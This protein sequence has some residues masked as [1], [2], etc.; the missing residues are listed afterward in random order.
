M[1]EQVGG[2]FNEAAVVAGRERGNRVDRATC[3]HGLR[4]RGDRG[5]VLVAVYTPG[6]TAQ[7]S[8]LR[9]AKIRIPSTK[10]G[11]QSTVL[12]TGIKGAAFSRTAFPRTVL[13]SAPELRRPPQIPT[14]GSPLG[15]PGLR[16]T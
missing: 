10:H 15:P 11:S 13:P 12:V 6:S 4:T 16:G 8:A 1:A 3:I 14:P 2:Y 5:F 9:F 7:A